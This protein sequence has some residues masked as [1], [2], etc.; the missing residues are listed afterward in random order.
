LTATSYRRQLSPPSH[1]LQP[2][3][4]YQ[5][6]RWSYFLIATVLTVCFEVAGMAAL[7]HAYN[8][9]DATR[10]STSEFAWF[11]LGM[12]L[13]ELP[14][15]MVIA[16][17]ATPNPM[18]TA[19]LTFYGLVSYAPKLLRNPTGPIYHDEFAHWRATYEILSTG[20]LFQPN[21]IIPI[22]ARYPGLHAATASLVHATGLTIWQAG[23]I[24]LVLFHVTLVLGIAVLAQ[25]L[26]FNNRT[27]SLIALLYG[28]NSSFLYFD[29]QYAYE[30]MAITLVVWTLVA[31]VRAIRSRPGEGRAVWGVLTLL[32]SAGTIIT[33]HLSTF[34]LVQIMTLVSLVVSVPWLARGKGWPREGPPNSGT[35][36]GW[37]RESWPKGWARDSRPPSDRRVGWGRTALTA[38]SLTLATALMAGA[39]FRF[40]A[41]TTWSYL[42]PFLGEGLSELMQ[43]AKGSGGTRQLFGASLSPGWE[44]KSAYLVPLVTLCLALGGLLSLRARMRDGRLPRGGRRALLVAFALLGLVYFPS[45]LFILSPSGAEGARRSWAF[46]WI[47]LCMLAGPVVVWLLD[48]AGSRSHQWTRISLRS[49]LLALLAAVLIGGTAAGLDASY[50]LPGPFLYGSDARSIT[51]ELIGTAKWFTARF[52]PDNNVVTDRYTGLVFG[53]SGLQNATSP[54]SGLPFY[55]LYLAKPGAQIGPSFLLPR[56]KR[57]GYTYMIVDGNMA[58]DLPQLGVYF[59]SADPV[60]LR[61]QGRKPIFA[62]RLSK[63]NTFQ[64]MIKVFQSDTYS[65]YRLDLPPTKLSYEHQPPTTRGRVLSGKLVVTP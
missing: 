15:A 53:S 54:F 11:W 9:A 47:G 61:P 29:T 46:T 27:A 20:K 50:R 38:W 51:P 58:Y 62:G 32:L 2:T 6:A 17:Q 65:I 56:L 34:T 14:L 4:R 1:R 12:I 33:H 45:T 30:S 49:G 28:L 37:A 5:G 36:E 16:R 24:L 64:W 13:L 23:T 63:F 22:I 60:S 55:N 8:I 21:P 7:V 35:E 48:W 57:S 52:G 31:Y 44:Q 26:G 43:A 25:A 41:P 59:T 19:L 39:W 40:V 10:T 42:S 18:R 3:R